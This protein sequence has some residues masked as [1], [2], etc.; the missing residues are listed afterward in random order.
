MKEQRLKTILINETE[1]NQGNNTDQEVSVLPIRDMGTD[2]AQAVVLQ[3]TADVAHE[4]LI[5]SETPGSLHHYQSHC[6]HG[7]PF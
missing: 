5:H 1:P 2:Q 4:E 6:Q 3:G 7:T